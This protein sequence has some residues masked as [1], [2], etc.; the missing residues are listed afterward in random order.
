[1]AGPGAIG[2][3]FVVLGLAALVLVGT[4]IRT[5]AEYVDYRRSG[6]V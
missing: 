5:V 3:F 2:V 4:L 6:T 1:M